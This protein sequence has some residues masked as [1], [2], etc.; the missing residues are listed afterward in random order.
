MNRSM[1]LYLLQVVAYTCLPSHAI[2]NAVVKCMGMNEFAISVRCHLGV[3]HDKV[4]ITLFIYALRRLVV[5]D[6]S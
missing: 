6:A 2:D 1:F 3:T 5:Y 4:T